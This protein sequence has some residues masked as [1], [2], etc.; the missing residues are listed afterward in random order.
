MLIDFDAMKAAEKRHEAETAANFSADMEAM[1]ADKEKEE[2]ALHNT[3]QK[4]FEK[5]SEK[6]R[7][8]MQ[9]KQEKAARESAENIRKAYERE[10]AATWNEGKNTAT[11]RGFMHDLME[12]R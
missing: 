11:L 7:K 9:A 12:N 6:K 10:N 1:R 4:V 8:E 5:N 2:Q 3:L